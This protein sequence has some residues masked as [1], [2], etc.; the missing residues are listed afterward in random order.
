M[1]FANIMCAKSQ[2]DI[3]IY[4]ILNN[5]DLLKITKKIQNNA[6]QDQEDNTRQGD[7]KAT[8][9]PLDMKTL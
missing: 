9:C 7:T 6:K 2:M 8:R 4:N 5:Y 1:S 3:H